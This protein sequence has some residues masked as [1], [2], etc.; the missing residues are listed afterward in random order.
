M[1]YLWIYFCKNLYGR[2]TLQ[3]YKLLLL[4]S[5]IYQSSVTRRLITCTEFFLP[6]T[7]MLEISYKYLILIHEIHLSQ[8]FNVS[9]S[10][11]TELQQTMKYRLISILLIENISPSQIITSK[12]KSLQIRVLNQKCNYH[13]INL[14]HIFICCFKYFWLIL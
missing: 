10:I 6:E 13:N 1:H 12:S 5:F 14:L 9:A 2:Q 11:H 7:K 8:L 3:V 4:I